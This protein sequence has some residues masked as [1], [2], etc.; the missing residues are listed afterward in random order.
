M[1]F[2]L[3]MSQN[4][5]LNL[6]EKNCKKGIMKRTTVKKLHRVLLAIVLLGTLNS[7]DFENEVIQ[8]EVIL[9]TVEAQHTITGVV[10]AISGDPIEN[11]TVTLQGME[12][13][14]T[15]SDANGV[16]SFRGLKKSG[17]YVIEASVGGKLTLSKTVVLNSN[18]QRPLEMVNFRMTNASTPQQINLSSQTVVSVATET[19]AGNEAFKTVLTAVVPTDISPNGEKVCICIQPRYDQTETKLTIDRFIIDEFVVSLVDEEGNPYTLPDGVTIEISIHEVIE[20]CCR[21]HIAYL[22]GEVDDFTCDNGNITFALKGSADICI[23]CDVEITDNTL[24]SV[25]DMSPSTIDRIYASNSNKTDV[26]YN[27]QVGARLFG[28]GKSLEILQKYLAVCDGLETVTMTY[29][30]DFVVPAGAK[31]TFSAQQQHREVTVD[32]EN[33]PAEGTVYEDVLVQS[34]V[35]VPSHNGGGN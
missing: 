34:E 15:I 4:T 18:N 25:L 23:C 32:F 20:N 28:S 21:I 33:N 1:R 2:T 27:M 16:Y 7:C 22:D 10:S 13:A 19:V 31:Y 5:L 24:M 12:E 30:A 11:A 8:P 35:I 17:T 14:T 3:D 29:L 26:T 6:N 9:P